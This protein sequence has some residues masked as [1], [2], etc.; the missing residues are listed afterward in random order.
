MSNKGTQPYIYMYPLSPKLPSHPLSGIT[1]DELK[2]RQEY[3]KWHEDLQD[4]YFLSW[5]LLS[6]MQANEVFFESQFLKGGSI[7]FV[8]QRIFY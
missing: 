4:L 3:E 1:F 2:L 6:N 8:I 5:P 7:V